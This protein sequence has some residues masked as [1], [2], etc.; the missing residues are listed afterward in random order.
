MGLFRIE[1][2][3][4][5]GPCS[6][7]VAPIRVDLIALKIGTDRPGP[8]RETLEAMQAEG[9]C[10][11][12]AQARPIE[13]DALRCQAQFRVEAFAFGCSSPQRIVLADSGEPGLEAQF[14]LPKGLALGVHDEDFKPPGSR[15]SFDNLDR[16]HGALQGPIGNRCGGCTPRRGDLTHRIGIR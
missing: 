12:H 15:M 14:D 9:A 13:S 11:P 5:V 10:D 8:I 2:D 7:A 6:A 1:L 16:F 4:A 3:A